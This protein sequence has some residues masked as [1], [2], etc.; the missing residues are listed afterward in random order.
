MQRDPPPDDMRNRL[1]DYERMLMEADRMMMQTVQ[2]SL[3]LIGFGFTITTFFND[4]AV[5]M[6]SRD[7]SENAR[8]LGVALLVIG[9]TLLILGTWSQSR[10]RAALRSRYLEGGP[11]PAAWQG[12]RSRFTPS[13]IAAVMLMAAGLFTLATVILRWLV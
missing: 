2:T 4:V 11:A 1:L 3:S 9:L 13:Y 7:G 6:G 10:Y 12:L 5:R 8:I